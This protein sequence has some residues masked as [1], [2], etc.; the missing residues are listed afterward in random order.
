MEEVRW[1]RKEDADDC[2]ASAPPSSDSCASDI[3]LV[4]LERPEEGVEDP[5]EMEDEVEEVEES[6]E[7]HVSSPAPIGGE[8]LEPTDIVDEAY[9]SA[10]ASLLAAAP[11]ALCGVTIGE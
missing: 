4:A 3:E 5:E 6:E 10:D 8:K 1:E 9:D 11:L 2:V 7:A